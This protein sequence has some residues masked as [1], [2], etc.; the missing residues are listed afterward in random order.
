MERAQH[1]EGRRCPAGPRDRSGHGPWLS[2]TV[3]QRQMLSQNPPSCRKVLPP[4][5]Q[6]LRAVEGEASLS[7][8][9]DRGHVGSGPLGRDGS[10]RPRAYKDCEAPPCLAR[11]GARPL[12]LSEPTV[13]RPPP[14]HQARRPPGLPARTVS[15]PG[16]WG[17]GSG[18][19]RA[20]APSGLS[21]SPEPLSP[22]AQISQSRRG[23]SW[24]PT[25]F[26]QL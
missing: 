7:Q 12:R 19:S 15:G 4:A 22:A 23:A 16:R 17:K 21:G 2:L 6:L 25:D 26:G 10:Q 3:S 20:V 24:F 14:Q 8:A 18:P 9:P 11:L 1:T 5:P 13:G